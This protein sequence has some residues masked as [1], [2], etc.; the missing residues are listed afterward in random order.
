MWQNAAVAVQHLNF[1]IALLVFFFIGS[2]GVIGVGTEEGSGP[3]SVTRALSSACPIGSTGGIRT[4]CH[5]NGFR[6][7][8]V[9]P[10][11]PHTTGLTGLHELKKLL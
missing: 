8:W 4:L 5:I 1:G 9:M 6:C 11:R 10:T 3:L 2:N 7:S